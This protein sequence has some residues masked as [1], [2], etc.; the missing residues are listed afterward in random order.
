M[1][2]SRIMIFGAGG[3]AKVIASLLAP[4]HPTFVVREPQASDQISESDVFS[5]I[6][7]Y[8]HARFYIGIGDNAVRTRIFERLAAAD[9]RP[10]TCIAPTA[11]V[12]PDA[13]IGAGVVVCPGAVVMTGAVLGDNVIV[14]TLSGVDHDCRIGDH[15]Q[16]SVGV[17]L[18]GGVVVGRSC[19]VGLKAG[20]FPQVTIGDGVIVRAGSLVT[21]DQPDRV[22]IGGSPARVMRQ[23]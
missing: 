21:S 6:D 8:R 2:G 15:S 13:S 5:A 1:T 11:F 12:A 18:A 19:F 17:T 9:I 3:H 14:N 10:A 22:M 23:L 4:E 16:I 7:R 20:F